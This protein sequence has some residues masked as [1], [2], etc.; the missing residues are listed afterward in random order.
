MVCD[1][2]TVQSLY[3]RSVC[4]PESS[5]TLQTVCV[6]CLQFSH[7][8]DDLCVLLTIQSLFR[9]SVCSAYSSVTLQTVCVFCLQ[10]SHSSDGLCV[11]L[12]VQSLF[13]RSV[14]SAYSSFTVQTAW[15]QSLHWLNNHFEVLHKDS[16]GLPLTIY[17]HSLYSLC[18]RFAKCAPLFPRD[19]L[20]HFYNGFFE[21]N[22]FL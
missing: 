8:S 2:L 5:V 13:R 10:F 14:C 6:F 16:G 7:S 22:F 3:R 18:Q 11:L 1:L 12:T 9:R 4:S 17:S 19:P 20:I 15:T 21:V